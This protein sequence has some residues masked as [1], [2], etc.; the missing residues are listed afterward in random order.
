MFSSL[1]RFFSKAP[2][3][4]EGIPVGL[5]AAG[6]LAGII[7]TAL[8]LALGTVTRFEQIKSGW[9]SFSHQAE[10]K[11]VWISQIRG[12][13]G[14]G[15]MIHNFK[16]YVLRRDEIYIQSLG[17]EFKLLYEPI[18]A[19]IASHPS[20]E[21]I[22]A[23]IAVRRTIKRY[24]MKIPII[25]KATQ[26]SWT[27]ERLDQ[28]VKVN[29]TAALQGLNTLETI[30]WEERENKISELVNALS[31][32][33]QLT[34]YAFIGL[35]VLIILAALLIGLMHFL[36]QRISAS[37]SQL[38][39]ELS[40]RKK[41]Q[42]AEKKLSR[43]VEQSPTTIAITDTQGKI[44]YVNRKFCEL[45]GY[46]KQE[47]I[48][49]TPNILKSG[50]T[51]QEAYKLIWQ[52]IGNGQEWRGIFKNLKKDGSF[53]WA[54]TAILP[55]KDEQ[56]HITNFIGIGED[57]TEKKAAQQHIVKAQKMEAVGLL[58]G[59][60]AH[61]FNNILMV[62][63]GN[64]QIALLEA[65]E[66]AN[67]EELQHIEIAARRAQSLVKQLLTFARRQ[68]ASPRSLHLG[69]QI[70]EILILL[71]SS[72]ANTITLGFERKCA[73]GE[74]TIM[75][76][77]TQIHQILMN[78]SR[79]AA[80]AIGGKAGSIMFELSR[81]TLD[82]PHGLNE[83]PAKAQGIVKLS[84]IDTGPGVPDHIVERI[85][86]PFYST[87]PIGKGTGLG[88]SVVRSLVEDMQGR[89]EVETN[90]QGGTI[91][92][93]YFPLIEAKDQIETQDTILKGGHEQILLV[94]DEEEV[95][96]VMRRLLT[97]LGYRVVAFTSSQSALADFAMDPHRYN[98]LLTDL[99]MP[100]LGGEDLIKA[101]RAIRPDLPIILST[102]YMQDSKEF[103]QIEKFSILQKPVDVSALAMALRERLD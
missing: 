61:D 66:A 33:E 81:L 39:K 34:R 53:Y 27:A 65:D 97:R 71:R 88:L 89:I 40:A 54:S 103:S 29:D 42:E 87:K 41:A 90:P 7:L 16:N 8:F 55:L 6:L 25:R 30:W 67:S 32:G 38:S 102:A 79:N 96:F 56:G 74:C 63:L 1:N 44:E 94:D 99:V 31:S 13:F 12:H 72:I 11:G 45:T 57:I 60:I 36:I 50:Y 17:E 3:R 47:L 73:L 58:A 86:D 84:V 69:Q 10:E 95:L 24:E 15:G 48:G 28:A 46:E 76:D 85:F 83:L 9:L 75:A 59:G 91:M 14:Y 92:S 18:D 78:L 22:K 62:I 70:D 100:D 64:V 101:V 51:S 77:P 21:E 26:E 20:S 37:A 93:L 43:A 35:F 4:V 2:E 23:L 19:Y 5:V 52:R 82:E 49:R 80:E 98:L 68:P